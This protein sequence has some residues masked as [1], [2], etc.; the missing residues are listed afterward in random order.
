MWNVLR[1]QGTKK[2]TKQPHRSKDLKFLGGRDMTELKTKFNYG[3]IAGIRSSEDP[4]V[5]ANERIKKQFLNL[6]M[7]L[8]R[9]MDCRQTLRLGA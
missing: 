9:E 7:L 5:R 1:K 8:D 6:V 3:S 4:K 2:T